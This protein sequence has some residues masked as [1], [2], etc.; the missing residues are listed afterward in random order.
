MDTLLYCEINVFSITLLGI[1]AYRASKFGLDTNRKK[2]A[3]LASIFSAMAMNFLNIIWNFCVID[4]VTV[5]VLLCYFIDLL[6]FAAF[7]LSAFFWYV[8][9]EIVHSG[10]ASKLTTYLLLIIPMAVL[11]IFCATTPTNGLLYTFDENG[12]YHRGP[13][14]LLQFLPA[15]LYVIIATVNNVINAL[16]PN[17]YHKHET[18]VTMS[19]Y[20][21]PIII[22]SVLQFVFVNGPILPI[23]PTI[24]ILLVFTNSLKVQLS[25][26]PLTGIFN[27]N[28]IIDVLSDKTKSPKKNKKLYFIFIDI[29]GFKSLN[30]KFGHDEGD[31][32][33]QIV[34]DS[35]YDIFS[36]NGG[37]C[38]RYGGD[39]FA[40]VIEL[41]NS[42]NID[43]LCA[44]IEEYVTV[45][46]NKN[47][48]SFTVNI[49]IGYGEYGKDATTIPPLIRFAD[50]QMYENKK[51]RNKQF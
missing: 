23:A 11:V 26:D 46:S 40:A 20:C 3:F 49:S 48:S 14:F 30:D 37:S 2:K 7:S 44:E 12:I 45:N 22:C 1:M 6:F 39:E 31:K 24:S 21:V 25:V 47:N 10:K 9:T 27:R 18:Y 16:E 13:L 43:D 28:K 38:A 19:F 50:K 35:L 15:L 32:A 29:D 5:P 33:L 51:K 8:F 42:Q 41:D 34:A 4:T 36:H 17:N